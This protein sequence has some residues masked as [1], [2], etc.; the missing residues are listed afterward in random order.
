MMTKYTYSAP[1]V[2]SMMRLAVFWALMIASVLIGLATL[3]FIVGMIRQAEAPDLTGT[4]LTIGA[5]I[6]PIA[7]GAKFGQKAVEK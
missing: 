3:G 7:L 1:D 4:F 5:G 6:I 2:Q